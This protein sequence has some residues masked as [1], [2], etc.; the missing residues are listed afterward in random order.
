MNKSGRPV[1]V[2]TTSVEKSEM[3]AA[4]LKDAEISCQVRSPDPSLE[5]CLAMTVCLFWAFQGQASSRYTK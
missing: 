3:L 1:L 4:R 2:G 5:L